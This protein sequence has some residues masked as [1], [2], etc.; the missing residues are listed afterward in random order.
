[1]RRKLAKREKEQEGR[2]WGQAL[3]RPDIRDMPAIVVPSSFPCA[4][5]IKLPLVDRPSQATMA[6]K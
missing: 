6:P 3:A 5:Q 4:V 1:M 2:R